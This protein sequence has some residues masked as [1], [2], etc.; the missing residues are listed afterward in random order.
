MSIIGLLAHGLTALA[1]TRA[2][3]SVHQFGHVELPRSFLLVAAPNKG[4]ANASGI[5]YQ[6]PR[7]ALAS[8][9]SLLRVVFFPGF[10]YFASCSRKRVS[11][12]K[13]SAKT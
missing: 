12:E 10:A 1:H 2:H 7:L 9:G 8:K 4:R 13:A 6:T 3:L 5:A 11:Q